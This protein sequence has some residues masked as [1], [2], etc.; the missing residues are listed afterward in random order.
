MDHPWP[1]VSLDS[2]ENRDPRR[3]ALLAVDGI[4]S[5]II[6]ASSATRSRRRSS[7]VM[8]SVQFIDTGAQL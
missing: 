1:P 4:E 6:M 8:Q 2:D 3:A 7:T 5:E